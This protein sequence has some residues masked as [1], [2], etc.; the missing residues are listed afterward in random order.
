MQQST[1]KRRG[2]EEHSSSKGPLLGASIHPARENRFVDMVVSLLQVEITL[3]FARAM[4]YM[5]SR[6]PVIVHRDLKPANIMVGGS[7]FMLAD[8]ATLLHSAGTIKV[9]DFGLSKSL[10]KR[11]SPHV[12]KVDTDASGDQSD[13]DSQTTGEVYRLTGVDQLVTFCLTPQILL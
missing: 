10:P 1:S 6:Q 3:E 7:S 2:F 11:G 4:A 8:T 9:A 12:V 13:G 5:H